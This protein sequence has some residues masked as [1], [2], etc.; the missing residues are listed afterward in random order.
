MLIPNFNDYK[1]IQ[2]NIVD[3]L[4]IN[5]SRFKIVCGGCS[6]VFPPLGIKCFLIFN[7]NN[8]L[9]DRSY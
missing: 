3:Y 5:K 9:I 6:C 7:N 4:E 1:Q 2:G 8:L